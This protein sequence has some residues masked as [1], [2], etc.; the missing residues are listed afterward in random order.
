MVAVVINRR[1]VHRKTRSR[2]VLWKSEL[3]HDCE[4]NSLLSGASSIA[5]S[6]LRET[7]VGV[8]VRHE[9]FFG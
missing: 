3:F 6:L 7:F 4:A 1:E 8:L 2:I 9:R 5:S